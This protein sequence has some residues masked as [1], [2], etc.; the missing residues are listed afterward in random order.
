[1][2]HSNPAQGERVQLDHVVPYLAQV[3]YY[4]VVV[5]HLQAQQK[6]QALIVCITGQQTQLLQPCILA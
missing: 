5:Q 1:M 2:D 4:V 6:H 3:P